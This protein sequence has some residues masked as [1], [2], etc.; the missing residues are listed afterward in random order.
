MGGLGTFLCLLFLSYLSAHI[1]L[2]TFLLP[3]YVPPLGEG[4]VGQSLGVDG[5]PTR[6]GREACGR[7][8][9]G[10]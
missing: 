6:G 5:S 8:L 1:P 2:K 10:D 7:S 4:C 9:C 3:R